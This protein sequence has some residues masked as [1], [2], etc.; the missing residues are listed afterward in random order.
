MEHASE[1][2]DDVDGDTITPRLLDALLSGADSKQLQEDFLA[3][4]ISD[5]PK[6]LAA[7]GGLRFP[8]LPEGSQDQPRSLVGPLSELLDSAKKH[9]P[10]QG[11]LQTLPPLTARQVTSR[12]SLFFTSL[13]SRLI[14]SRKCLSDQL[15]QLLAELQM[16]SGTPLRSLRQASVA[17]AL[18]ALQALLAEAAVAFAT[19]AEL[20]GQQATLLEPGEPKAAPAA[21]RLARLCCAVNEVK[22]KAVQLDAQAKKMQETVLLPRLHDT[23]PAVRRLSL[24]ALGRMMNLGLLWWPERVLRSLCDPATE[25]RVQAVELVGAWFEGSDDHAAEAPEAARW[26]AER[27][28]DTEPRVAAL[29]VRQLRRAALASQLS[30]SNFEQ[31]SMLSLTAPDSHGLLRAEAALFVEQHLLPDPGLG[32]AVKRGEEADAEDIERHFTTEHGL[33][34]VAD[35]LTSYLKDHLLHL[36][37]RFVEALW[38]RTDCFRRWAALADLC[39]LGEGQGAARGVPCLPNRQRLALLFV[40]DGAL[41][42]AEAPKDATEALLPRLPRLFEL[43]ASE[44]GSFPDVL[45]S[46][47]RRMICSACR[48]GESE[49]P[50]P[51]ALLVPVVTALKKSRSKRCGQ[52]DLAEALATWAH[53]S[54]EVQAATSQ[55][56]RDLYS[57]LE[58]QMPRPGAA[59]TRHPPSLGD[60]ATLSPL[61]ALGRRGVDLWSLDKTGCSNNILRSTVHVLEA[62]NNQVPG[63]QPGELSV[64]RASELIELMVLLSTWRARQLTL[65][66]NGKESGGF[67]MCCN[68]ARACCAKV[69]GG[70]RHLMLRFQAFSG[71]LLL[72]QLEY[73]GSLVEREREDIGRSSS[74]TLSLQRGEVKMCPLDPQSGM[75]WRSSA[76][77]ELVQRE[78]LALLKLSC[79]SMGRTCQTEVLLNVPHVLQGFFRRKVATTCLPLISSHN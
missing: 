47:T 21:A 12:I 62:F 31:V 49:V 26:L 34:A 17:A 45:A 7:L 51:R 6:L 50:L 70:E 54:S 19:V 15:L 4:T 29:A 69:M 58:A 36:S 78:T 14:A 57:S 72:L 13:V 25:V 30:D 32:I 68:L 76:P 42:C 53:R 1:A 9:A 5:G 24:N 18:G 39:L 75:F 74:G 43:F 55:L 46:I 38:V 44:E 11:T 3:W 22:T 64:Q 37:R 33:I 66:E 35:F 41:H 8:T 59:L 16:L 77:W 10:V 60:C 71:F 27:S 61:L 65:S 79:I 67:L 40:L 52:A 23:A 2:A 48:P 20:E 73:L 56:V 63:G 28:R